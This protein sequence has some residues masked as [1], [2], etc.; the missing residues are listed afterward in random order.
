MARKSAAKKGKSMK[1]A[2]KAVAFQPIKKITATRNAYTKSQIYDYIGKRTG[3]KRAQVAASMDSLKELIAAHVG[4]QGAGAFT[5]PGLM[6][7]KVVHKPATKA[8]KG[9]NPFTG[10][11][12]TFKAKPARN[13]IKIR[14]LKSL[15]EMV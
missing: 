13:V 4:K 1:S 14:A 9:I 11:P 10:E 15:K 3:I 5:V 8:R 2:K 12:T 6:K 7:L